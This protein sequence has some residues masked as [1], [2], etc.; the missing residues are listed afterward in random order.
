MFMFEKEK[1][2]MCFSF[3]KKVLIFIAAKQYQFWELK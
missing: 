2:V 3:S 1:K